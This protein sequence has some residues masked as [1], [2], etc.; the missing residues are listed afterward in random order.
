[1]TAGTQYLHLH[2]VGKLVIFFWQTDYILSSSAFTRFLPKSI[3]KES[4][5]QK[6]SL[7][8]MKK[9]FKYFFFFKTFTHLERQYCLRQGIQVGTETQYRERNHALS[10]TIFSQ[11]FLIV[12]LIPEGKGLKGVS[13]A[14]ISL[15][16]NL[17]S[18]LCQ[19]IV[20]RLKEQWPKTC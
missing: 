2:Q 14:R 11:K 1:M 9:K 12:G 16:N 13:K 3:Q 10:H 5:E 8:F 17:V 7:S 4:K 20:H 6:D 15:L 18:G 19:K